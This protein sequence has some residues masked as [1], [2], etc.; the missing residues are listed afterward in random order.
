MVKT[1]GF[2]VTPF[3][4]EQE[5]AMSISSISAASSAALYQPT[6]GGVPLS[7]TPANTAVPPAAQVQQAGQAAQTG[8]LQETGETQRHHHRGG[9]GSLGQSSQIAQS[10]T[11]AAGSLLNA[12]V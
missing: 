4:D 7:A 6:K 12:L 5:A 2:I 9:T 11:T 3:T 8:Q 10:G 1:F